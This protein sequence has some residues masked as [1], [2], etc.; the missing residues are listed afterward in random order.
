MLQLVLA[1][2]AAADLG[3]YEGSERD[4]VVLT[5]GFAVAGFFVVYL[6][7]TML[8]LYLRNGTLFRK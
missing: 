2:A 6:L 4:R 8:L 3:P 1:A 7:V 5:R